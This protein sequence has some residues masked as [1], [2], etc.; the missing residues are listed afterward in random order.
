MKAAK[1]LDRRDEVRGRI[2]ASIDNKGFVAQVLGR[3][4]VLSTR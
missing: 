4:L 3:K 1:R 2:R